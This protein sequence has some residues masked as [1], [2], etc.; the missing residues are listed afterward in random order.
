MAALLV[1][2]LGE[3]T[4]HTMITEK[5]GIATL[6]SHDYQ[7]GWPCMLVTVTR[8]TKS[9]AIIMTNGLM[10]LFMLSY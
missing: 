9:K 7:H 5:E 10:D 1:D 8:V 4:I 2:T 6:C 3:K